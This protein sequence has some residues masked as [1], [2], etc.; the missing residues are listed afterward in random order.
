MDA[1]G[2]LLESAVLVTKPRDIGRLHGKSGLG[3]LGK[4]KAL[5]LDLLEAVFLADEGK[6]QVYAKRN[7]VPFSTLVAT[8]ARLVPEFETTYLV[9]RDLRKRGYAVT[10]TEGGPVTFTQ[11][12]MPAPYNQPLL[13]CAF[14]ERDSFAIDATQTLTRSA[15]GQGGRLWYALVDEEGDL[16]YYEIA[17]ADLR[18]EVPAQQYAKTSGLLLEDRLLIFD[19]VLSAQLLSKEFFG[20]PF[21]TGLQLSLV[22]AVY[23]QERGV[24]SIATPDGKSLSERQVKQKVSSLQPDIARRLLVFK[25]LKARGLLV[26]TGF[27]FGADFR[28][29]STHPDHAHAEFLIHVVESGYTSVWSEVSRAVRLAHTVNKE[30][31][32]ATVSE[33]T[34]EYVRFGR[35]R[36]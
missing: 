31:L 13:A 2:E 23:L 29:Y 26:K 12:R 10:R 36:P 3:R 25:D 28:A 33:T 18:G 14:S 15:A 30:F 1:T 22:E 4:D 21:G 9:F 17:S 32:L 16:T 6:L 8:A 34:I 24:L 19:S 5:R 7:K 27:K 11:P 35:L 20:K